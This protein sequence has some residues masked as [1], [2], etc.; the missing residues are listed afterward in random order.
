MNTTKGA[1]GSG[2][3]RKLDE[4]GIPTLGKEKK[5]LKNDKSREQDKNKDKSKGEKG[6]GTSLAGDK[7]TQ[8]LGGKST[9]DEDKPEEDACVICMEEKGRIVGKLECCQ[10]TF[11]ATCILKV[12]F[13]LQFLVVFVCPVSFF[14]QIVAGDRV[15]HG[16][17]NRRSVFL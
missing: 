5:G 9:Q 15:D 7:P 1:T 6:K 16:Q 10:H 14:A 11:C 17:Q 4:V 3:K 12:L 8:E 2:R 13:A